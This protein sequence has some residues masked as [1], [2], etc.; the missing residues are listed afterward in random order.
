[1]IY[2]ETTIYKQ[3]PTKTSELQNDSGFITRG[4]WENI[5]NKVG[6]RVNSNVTIQYNSEL[7]LLQFNNWGNIT[8]SAKT[9]V[10]TFNND[11]TGGPFIG[12]NINGS[13]FNASNVRVPCSF[14]VRWGD[15]D[16]WG[17]DKNTIYVEEN[18][19]SCNVLNICVCNKTDELKN[20]LDNH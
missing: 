6:T 2:K 18:V 20:Y 14:C 16:D 3:G 11:F 4:T 13:G 12:A 17:A 19:R 8:N 9:T 1:M 15:L 10:F 5:T 7:G